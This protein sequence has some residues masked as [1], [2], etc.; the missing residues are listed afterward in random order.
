MLRGGCRKEEIEEV[1]MVFRISKY[2]NLFGLL[3]FVGIF[4]VDVLSGKVF[5]VRVVG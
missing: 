5:I 2:F 3:G 1:G 4:W